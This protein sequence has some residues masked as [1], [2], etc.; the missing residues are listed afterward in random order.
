MNASGKTNGRGAGAG[1]GASASTGAPPAPNYNRRSTDATRVTGNSSSAR[2][3]LTAPLSGHSA[4]ARKAAHCGAGDG[5]SVDGGSWKMQGHRLGGCSP[6]ATAPISRLARPTIASALRASSNQQSVKHQREQAA[7][8]LTATLHRSEKVAAKSKRAATGGWARKEAG[9][10]E[11]A[12]LAARS[13]LWPSKKAGGG[14]ALRRKKV[15]DA[16]NL[17][18]TLEAD[19]AGLEA[20]LPEED[21]SDCLL[22]AGV[23]T[24]EEEILSQGPHPG[25]R[26]VTPSQPLMEKIVRERREA[27][28][29]LDRQA[30]RRFAS[31]ELEEEQHLDE[32]KEFSE[33][34]AITKRSPKKPPPVMYASYDN[35]Y[36]NVFKSMDDFFTREIP[37]S[38][39][40]TD[41]KERIKRKELELL[42][43]FDGVDS[44]KE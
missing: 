8:A 22:E 41:I 5:D 26:V 42:S 37:K 10:T 4:G 17:E 29:R 31:Y 44:T 6:A 30:T 27:K 16:M 19:D 32:L 12:K 34:N 24:N 38:E 35:Q 18:E 2:A 1:A 7:A 43:L 13:R 20:D 11:S 21:P 36:Q 39:S 23:Q 9:M 25:L 40:I 3:M 33:R 15:A 28:A 14:E